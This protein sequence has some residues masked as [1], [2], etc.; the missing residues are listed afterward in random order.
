MQHNPCKHMQS[1]NEDGVVSG[2]TLKIQ[3]LLVSIPDMFRDDLRPS[4]PRE[5][6]MSGNMVKDPNPCWFVIC[7]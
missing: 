2:F 1:I 6:I 7:I 3:H 5:I 4:D